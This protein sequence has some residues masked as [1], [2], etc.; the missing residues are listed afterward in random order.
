MIF[1]IIRWEGAPVLTTFESRD[2]LDKWLNEPETRTKDLKFL[3]TKGDI[4]Y[5][6]IRGIEEWPAN[7]AIIIDG[8]ALR[9][10]TQTVAVEYKSLG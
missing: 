4:N 1:V 8:E 10:I 5:S 3:A 9:V 6:F 2:K 7:T